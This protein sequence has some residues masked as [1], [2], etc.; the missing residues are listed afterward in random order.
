MKNETTKDLAYYLALPYTTILRRDEDGDVI[1]RI[2]ELPGCITH[3]KDEAEALSNIAKMKT[4][5]LQDSIEAGELAPEPEVEE[6]LPSGRWVQRVPRKLHAKLA[7]MAKDECISLNQLVTSMLS[8]KLGKREVQK[9]IEQFFAAC[10]ATAIAR[11][12]KYYWDK[13]V[14]EVASWASGPEHQVGTIWSQQ[15]LRKLAPNLKLS[16]EN[17]S[18]ENLYYVSR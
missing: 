3:G 4:L 11:D 9:E 7:R 13:S 15:G 5:W 18:K 12:P 14:F 8:E 2:A 1:A 6:P 16:V 17:A 10:N